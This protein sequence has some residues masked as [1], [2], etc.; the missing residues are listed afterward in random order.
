M[1]SP[2]SRAPLS[3]FPLRRIASLAAGLLALTLVAGGKK[4][5]PEIAVRFHLETNTVDAS[6]GTAVQL[7]DPPREMKVEKIPAI[8]ERNIVSFYPFKAADGTFGAAFRLDRLGTID[9][10]TL[11]LEHRTRSLLAVVNGRPVTPLTVDKPFHD[12]IIFI[13]FGLLPNDIRA[14][15][16]SW[17]IMGFQR[18]KPGQRPA[19]TPTPSGL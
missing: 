2:H 6:F 11:S 18:G 3:R 14:M 10:E 16:Q 17:P 5:D 8:S 13:P 9:L 1:V 4:Q 19:P 7:T 15:G 12:G